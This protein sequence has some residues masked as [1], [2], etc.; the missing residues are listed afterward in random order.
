[1]YP[2][3]LGTVVLALSVLSDTVSAGN[4]PRQT[5][6]YSNTTSS[7]GS[8]PVSL[9]RTPTGSAVTGVITPPPCCWIFG[10]EQA[11]DVNYWWT[12]T[13]NETIAT[14][15]TTYLQYRDTFVVANSTTLCKPKNKTFSSYG[16]WGANF[17]Q[18]SPSGL[19]GVPTDLIPSQ[20]LGAG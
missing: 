1:M 16:P 20:V 13:A 5:T 3:V 2:L 6:Q 8:N 10:G 18:Y 7:G 15:I 9:S 4:L 12:N 11:V 19:T 14:V 17:N